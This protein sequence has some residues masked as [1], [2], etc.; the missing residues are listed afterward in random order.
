MGGGS[1]PQTVYGGQV[2]FLLG[3]WGVVPS[4]V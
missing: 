1:I 4:R 2:R 3:E